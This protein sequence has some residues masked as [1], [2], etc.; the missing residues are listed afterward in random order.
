VKGSGEKHLPTLI[1]TKTAKI[2]SSLGQLRSESSL[3]LQ[4]KGR[5]VTFLHARAA[6][7]NSRVLEAVA[8]H[9]SADP[10]KKVKKMIK[11]MIV[12]LLKEA[13]KEAGHK[14]FCDK[15]LAVN[16]HTR[17]RKTNQVETMTAEVDQLTARIAKTTEE[18]SDLQTAVA[19]LDA[20]IAKETEQRAAEK[21]KNEDTVKDAKNAQEAVAQALT[22][23]K[24][25]YA[26]A[27]TATAFFQAG[28]K[29]PY[30]GMGGES[31]GVVAMLEVIQE[32]FARL[33]SETKAAEETS[34]DEFDKFM[35]ESRMDKADKSA[36]VT[37]KTQANSDSKTTLQTTQS[38]LEGTQSELTA[39][40]RT[41]DKLKPSCVDAG[42]SYEDRVKQRE[43]E[44][45]SLKEALKILTGE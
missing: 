37:H 21:A 38:D 20:A 42:V 13:N 27:A 44:I 16:K 24:E 19:E 12:K 39:A 18:I 2:A 23:L 33:E 3:N 35:Q 6:K 17:D 8:T 31:G 25:F 1:Q 34:Q 14:G 43:D 26:K 5:M 11:D 4:M 15:E 45:E 30:N 41:F 7:F 9:A 28:A 29:E 36:T 22:V 32:D 40:L 10:M